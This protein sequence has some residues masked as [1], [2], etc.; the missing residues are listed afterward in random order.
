MR[1]AGMFDGIGAFGLGLERAGLTMVSH[2]EIDEG[3][4]RVL[5]KHW[6]DTPTH[7]DATTRE[8]KEGEADVI[9]GGFPCQD[10]SQAGSRAGLAGPRS[11]LWR[12]MVRALRVVGPRHLIVENVA[13]LRRR[14][15]GT[16]LSDLAESGHDAEWDCIPASHVG[17][18]HLRDRLWLVSESQHSHAD[19]QRSHQAALHLAGGAE[20]FDQQERVAGPMGAPLA[21]SLAGVG[22]AGGRDWHPEPGVRRVVDGSPAEVVRI[23]QLG[24]SLISRIAEA[25]G[26]AVSVATATAYGAG[27]CSTPGSPK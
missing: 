23:K 20:L 9:C 6:P 1:V 3:C 19:R 27:D 17:A 21:R 4:R 26:S 7:T 24:N 18:P 22:P 2:T 10:L 11:G 14:G 5:R 13:A 25:L 16:V 15:L 8:W 12:E